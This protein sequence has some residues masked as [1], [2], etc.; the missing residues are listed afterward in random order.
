M[1]DMIFL[2]SER[3]FLASLIPTIQT[4]LQNLGL[5]L[6]PDKILLTNVSTG[7]LFL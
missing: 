3:D 6:H 7:F 4:F 2:H 5:T 1:D